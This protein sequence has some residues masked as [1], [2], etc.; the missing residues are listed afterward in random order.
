[1]SKIETVDAAEQVV[2][3]L[4]KKRAAPIGFLATLAMAEPIERRDHGNG[5]YWKKACQQQGQVFRE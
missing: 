4:E 1:M 3:N 2:T 5:C